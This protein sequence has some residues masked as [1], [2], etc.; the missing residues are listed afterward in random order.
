MQ[1]FAPISPK[2]EPIGT[3]C[4]SFIE[5]ETSNGIVFV[6]KFKI[7]SSCFVN[8]TSRSKRTGQEFRTVPAV[9]SRRCARRYVFSS[10]QCVAFLISSSVSLSRKNLPALLVKTS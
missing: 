5:C 6:Y 1:G 4:C 9:K 2:V 10:C 7:K 3:K 8:V